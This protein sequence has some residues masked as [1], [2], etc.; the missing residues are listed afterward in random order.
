MQLFASSSVTS[1]ALC[2]QSANMCLNLPNTVVHAWGGGRLLKSYASGVGI[3]LGSSAPP[4]TPL[5][6]TTGA[7]H[8]SHTFLYTRDQCPKVKQDS[9]GCLGSWLVQ[10]R[11]I[12]D[13]SVVLSHALCPRLSFSLPTP[14]FV[15]RT[16]EL[17]MC[18]SCFLWF[19]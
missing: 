1:L 14:T 19:F 8:D 3:I 12:A 13:D 9:W 7:F 11:C 18:V 5:R 6:K 4:L 2:E 17:W 16:Q 10:E 15:L